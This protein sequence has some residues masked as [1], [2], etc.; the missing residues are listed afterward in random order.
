LETGETP[1]TLRAEITSP[2]GTTQAGLG[3]LEESNF[4]GIVRSAVRAARNRSIELSAKK[5]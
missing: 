1:L 5:P 3:V 2:G 4:T